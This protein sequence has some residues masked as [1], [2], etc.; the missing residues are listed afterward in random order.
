MML[1]PLFPFQK[2]GPIHDVEIIFNERGS[3]VSE[4]RDCKSNREQ[5]SDSSTM[6]TRQWRLKL[7]LFRSHSFPGPILKDFATSHLQ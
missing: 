7:E 2:F 4:Q 6:A 1:N 5:T 3:K